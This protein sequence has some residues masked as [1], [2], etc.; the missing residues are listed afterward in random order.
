MTRLDFKKVIRICGH[1]RDEATKERPRYIYDYQVIKDGKHVATFKK[2]LGRIGYYLAD[3]LGYQIIRPQEPGRRVLGHYRRIL[4]RCRDDFASIFVEADEAELI[5]TAEQLAERE[6]GKEA[7]RKRQEAEELERQR[8]ARI[9]R[10]APKLLEAL[11]AFMSL[12]A[13]FSTAGREHV[14]TAAAEG[15]EMAKAVLLSRDAI[16]E[17]E[18]QP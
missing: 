16:A 3:V 7:E 11:K 13:T 9:E 10:A 14:E 8:I 15:D 6:A 17:A 4:A 18:G 1:N 5:P 2:E 12:D